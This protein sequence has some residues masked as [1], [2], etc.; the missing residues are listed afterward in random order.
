MAA[1]LQSENARLW[2][3]VQVLEASGQVFH[4]P[5]L[6]VPAGASCNPE[7]KEIPPGAVQFAAPPSAD[8]EESLAPDDSATDRSLAA[9]LEERLLRAE[10]AA[11]PDQ[12]AADPGRAGRRDAL[13]MREPGVAVGR[14]ASWNRQLHGGTAAPAALQSPLEEEE[15]EEVGAAGGLVGQLGLSDAMKALLQATRKVRRAAARHCRLE[16]KQDQPRS[17]CSSSGCRSRW[18]I[19]GWTRCSVVGAPTSPP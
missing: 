9:E 5:L 8:G 2:A 17:C 1:S 14:R 13:P 16:T 6:L 4:P 10:E 3:R 15:E 12:A 19:G 11:A 18:W 7:A